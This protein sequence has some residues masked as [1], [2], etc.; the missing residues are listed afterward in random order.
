MYFCLHTNILF[1]YKLD[2]TCNL[3]SEHIIKRK[4]N[5]IVFI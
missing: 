2:N 5:S 1:N 3:K 4:Y